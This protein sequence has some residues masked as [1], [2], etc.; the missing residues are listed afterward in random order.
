MIMTSGFIADKMVVTSSSL[1]LRDLILESKIEGQE[2]NWDSLKN[3]FE[4][5]STC[6]S[7]RFFRGR[8]SRLLHSVFFLEAL[9]MKL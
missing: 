7:Q 8:G 6:P 4:K 2:G 5:F 3:R 1:G 9:D